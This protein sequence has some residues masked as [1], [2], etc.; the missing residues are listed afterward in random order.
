M[1]EQVKQVCRTA[2]W[3]IYNISTIRSCLTQNA[4]AHLVLTQVV[5][6]EYAN[7]LLVGL[8]DTLI[9]KLQRVQNAA[10]RLVY[11]CSKRTHITP[12][13]KRLHWLHVRQRIR[14]KVLL[15]TFRAL[16]GLAPEYICDLLQPYTPPR[17]LRSSANHDL[18]IPTTNLKYGSRMFSVAAPRCWN[19]LPRELKSTQSLTSFKHS[20]KTHLFQEA[21]DC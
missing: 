10:A 21:Y 4:A 5:W 12:V 11:R 8:P 20:L 15:F 19:M 17:K 14:Y 6:L 7:A 2:Y 16:H 3:H 1:V 18:I 13:L 9:E